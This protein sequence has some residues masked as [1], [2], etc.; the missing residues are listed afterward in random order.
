ME[1]SDNSLFDQVIKIH[2]R[3]EGQMDVTPPVGMP[4]KGHNI[5]EVLRPEM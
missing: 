4:G 5:D 2:I 1:K 3:N